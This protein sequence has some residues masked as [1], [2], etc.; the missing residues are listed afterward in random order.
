MVLAPISANRAY[1]IFI[2]FRFSLFL[3]CSLCEVSRYISPMGSIS[4]RAFYA[5]PILYPLQMVVN[6][7]GLFAAQLLMLSPV[8]VLL[9][10]ARAQVLGH[11]NVVTADQIFSNPIY[12]AIPY[13]IIFGVIVLAA[14]YFKKIRSTLRKGYNMGNQKEAAISVKSLH[15]SFKLPHEQ[16][17]GVKQ[18][19]VGVFRRNR[20]KVTSYNMYSKVLI[21]K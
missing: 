8:A 2:L 4:A 19:L 1:D 17:S 10:Q 16:Y 5:T 18:L 14:I 20:K 3:V 6:V 15:K 13:V 9:Q 12:L 21:L 7:G 11:D